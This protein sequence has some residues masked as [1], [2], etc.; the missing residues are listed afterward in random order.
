MIALRRASERVR[1]FAHIDWFLLAAAVSISVL[2]LVTM[3]S[4]GSENSFFDK[5][6][7]WIALAL[8]VFFVAS[9][10]E[11]GFLRRTSVI[12]TLY[13]LVIALLAMVLVFG[14]VVKGA[15]NRFNLGLFA[16]QPSD[17]AKLLLVLL[18]PNTSHAGTLRSNTTSIFSFRA[19]T[20]SCFFCSSFS[21]PISVRASLSFR[22]GSVW[23][24]WRAS[25]GSIWPRSLLRR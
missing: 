8:G 25:R 15:Q 18:L 20:H 13:G 9:I 17:P 11:Y 14:S 24:S 19:P 1:A 21:S 16:V 6:I 5:Q 22:S 2:G 12:A 7:V 10:P 4:F 3:H 23:C